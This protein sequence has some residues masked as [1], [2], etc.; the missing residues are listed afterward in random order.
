MA[1]IG[2]V[3]G[4]SDNFLLRRTNAI[5][6]SLS[7]ELISNSVTKTNEIQDLSKETCEDQ[8]GMHK[9]GEYTGEV[10]CHFTKGKNGKCKERKVCKQVSLFVSI[11][12]F[13]FNTQCPSILAITNFS[14]PNKTPPSPGYSS[15][16]A[17][18][19]ALT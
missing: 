13:P 17:R 2:K 16:S 8:T 6:L 19:K 11:K 12:T 9:Y 7:S 10:S 1:I 4:D 14:E 5:S 3:P 15:R 18:S